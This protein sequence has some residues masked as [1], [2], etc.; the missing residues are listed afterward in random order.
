MEN[1]R[2]SIDEAHR[3]FANH[4]MKDAEEKIRYRIFDAKSFSLYAHFT[5]SLFRNLYHNDPKFECAYSKL[6]TE[7][8]GIGITAVLLN[9]GH[10]LT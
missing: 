1:K 8:K 7:V 4:L 10:K 6:E 2:L 9:K 5:L 3:M